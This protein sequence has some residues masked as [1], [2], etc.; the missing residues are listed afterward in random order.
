MTTFEEQIERVGSTTVLSGVSASVLS[1]FAFTTVDSVNI[2]GVQIPGFIYFALVVSVSTA[3]SSSVRSTIMPIVGESNIE[4]TPL[5]NLMIPI[6]TGLTTAVIDTGVEFLTQNQI[7]SVM[8][9][10]LTFLVGAGSHLT[11][12]TIQPVVQSTTESLTDAL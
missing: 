1:G 9:M 3:L 8:T 11:A 7:P 4:D 12:Q 6:S 2:A 5:A 10:F